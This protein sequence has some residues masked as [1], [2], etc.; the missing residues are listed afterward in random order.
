MGPPDAILGITEAFKR[1]TNS[2]KIN[3]GAGTYRDDNGQPYVLPSVLQVTCFNSIQFNSMDRVRSFMIN[4]ICHS[5]Q[6]SCFTLLN[7][8]SKI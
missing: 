1:D 3:L 2:K 7:R 5:I 8:P 4:I 6:S